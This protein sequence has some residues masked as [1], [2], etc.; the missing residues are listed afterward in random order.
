MCTYV[1]YAKD[2]LCVCASKLTR[3]IIVRNET[4]GNKLNEFN[5]QKKNRKEK[6][7]EEY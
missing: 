4:K 2:D 5:S 3:A 1:Y 7:K 6:A